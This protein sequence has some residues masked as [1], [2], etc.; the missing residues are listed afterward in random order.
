MKKL[1]DI[2]I[3][4]AHDRKNDVVDLVFQKYGAAHAA[5]LAGKHDKANEYYSALLKNCE[6]S[7][8]E[9]SELQHARE[10]VQLSAKF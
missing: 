6:G 4:F 1:P 3:D 7:K 9:R 2:D 5:E 10:Q 8:S